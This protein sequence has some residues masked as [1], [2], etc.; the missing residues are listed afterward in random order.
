M[1]FLA[2]SLVLSALTLSALA[3][4]PRAF[5]GFVTHYETSAAGRGEVHVKQVVPGSPADRAGVLAGDHILAFNGVTFVFP[6]EYEYMKALA[7][8]EKGRPVKLTLLRNGRELQLELVPGELSP[9]QQQ[10]LASYMR[11]LETCMKTGKNCP[12]PVDHPVPGATAEKEDFRSTYRQFTGSIP[13][14]GGRVV[15]TITR[16]AKGQIQY[17][18]APGPLP[19]H[20]EITSD[21]DGRL[22]QEIQKLTSG[23]KL[24]VEI[25]TPGPGKLRINLLSP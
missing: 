17:S 18:A 6:D 24:E 4:G 22:W 11:Q 7:V 19:E 10:G 15:L 1:R 5:W 8:F 2:L 12:C 3:E 25:S 9:Q 13:S 16:D 20:F 14:Q 21:D 23:A